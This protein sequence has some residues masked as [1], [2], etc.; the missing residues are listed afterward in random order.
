[1]S[2]WSVYRELKNGNDEDDSN[3][4]NDDFG[5]LIVILLDQQIHSQTHQTS[6][7]DQS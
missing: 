4:D 1:M 7:G 6:T 3:E 5:V 2:R